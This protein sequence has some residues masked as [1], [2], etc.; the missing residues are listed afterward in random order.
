MI[1]ILKIDQVKTVNKPWGLE[2]WIADGESKFPY[3]LKEIKINA[4]Y[5]SSIQ[6]HEKKQESNLIIEG[7]GILHYSIHPIDVNKYK[8]NRYTQEEINEIISN[9]KMIELVKGSVFHIYPHYIHSVEAIEDLLMIES[10]SLEVD[11]V[12][13]IQDDTGRGH[14]RI[15]SEHS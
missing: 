11:D 9:M 6:F 5:K 8:N 15:I 7:R 12:F 10:S 13:R 3:V 14:G 2:K 1:R 4:P